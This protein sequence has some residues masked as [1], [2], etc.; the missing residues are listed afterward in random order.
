MILTHPYPK[1]HTI[2]GKIQIFV[3]S[4]QKEKSRLRRLACAQTWMSCL[5]SNYEA[6]FVIGDPNL[7]C[8]HKQ[9]GNI[10]YLRC[11]D[12]YRGLPYK[13]KAVLRY[14]KMKD[15][16]LI[17]KCD[18]DTYVHP[19]RI[20]RI[21]L[22]SHEMCSFFWHKDSPDQRHPTGAFYSLSRGLVAAIE[23]LYNEHG[24]SED[25]QMGVALRRLPVVDTYHTY[26]VNPFGFD[27]ESSCIGHWLN[28]DA[29]RFVHRLTTSKSGGRTRVARHP[30]GNLLSF[31][32]DYNIVHSASPP[33]RWWKVFKRKGEIFYLNGQKF[34]MERGQ[35]V[36]EI[37][38]KQEKPARWSTCRARRVVSKRRR[39][40]R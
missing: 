40:K 11:N 25:T 36:E 15:F 32:L 37:P 34:R 22:S 1:S 13:T 7:P 12:T 20:D 21:P 30:D 17:V 18:D 33:Y 8:E 26:E 24:R 4:C 35:L 28:P 10:L 3:F 23:P 19:H 31:Y 6:R 38:K 27:M 9:D 14:A 2:S 29:M 39:I 5:P 16:P